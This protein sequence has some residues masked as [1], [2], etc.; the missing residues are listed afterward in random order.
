MATLT[1]PTSSAP[2]S[3]VD[4]WPRIVAL[5]TTVGAGLAAGV[6]FAFST[7][8]MAGLR[9]LPPAQGM[10]AMQAINK[11]APTP[12]FMILLFGT[13]VA[14]LVLAVV[15]LRDTSCP[16]AWYHV[17]GAAAYLVAIVMTIAY[18]VPHNDALAALD[19]DAPG[20]ARAWLTYA[21][22]WTLLN[23]VRTLGC[24]V[25]AALFALSLRAR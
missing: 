1:P 12:V 16:A 18:H 8:V 7:F 11:A 19:P 6:F 17:G 22:D 2:D 10:S 21:R 15:G 3:L 25:S 5:V 23:H 24:A 4:G 9:R 13:A 20:S 14:G